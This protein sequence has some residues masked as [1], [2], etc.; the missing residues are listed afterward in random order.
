MNL[1]L[2]LKCDTQ[3]IFKSA[4]INSKFIFKVTNK[5]FFDK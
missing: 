4:D 2:F 5:R 3:Y 1:Q